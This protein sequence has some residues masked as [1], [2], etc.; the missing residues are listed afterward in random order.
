MSIRN[1]LM[2][3]ARARR[4]LLA[5]TL[6]GGAL[7]A[8]G[9]LSQIVPAPAP[10]PATYDLGPMPGDTPAPLPR[11]FRLDGVAAP[12]WLAST[13]IWYRR[14]DLAPA[15]LRP[16][17]RNV[18]VANVSE[19]FEQRLAFR[20]AQAAPATPRDGAGDWP[21]GFELVSFE[22]VYAGADDAH[23]IARARASFEDASGRVQRRQ[24]ERRRPAAAS[25]E[26]ATAVMPLVADELIAD[27]I[28]WLR[29]A[30]A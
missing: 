21:L 13:N 10:P 26:G 28:E 6:A 12:S 30:A 1:N 25:V 27:V 23:V 4:A 5:A 14:L 19:L 3:G 2:P 11:R 22:H 7:L 20:L 17:A 29:L 9:C 18:W 15:A 16:Y 8:T 24:F